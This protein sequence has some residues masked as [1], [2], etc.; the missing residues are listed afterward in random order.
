[1]YVHSNPH[2][3]PS[4]ALGKGLSGSAADSGSAVHF[5]AWACWGRGLAGSAA[6]FI[7]SGV[8]F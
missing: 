6:D 3:L 5:M 2:A 4:R 1:M 8:G 7:A